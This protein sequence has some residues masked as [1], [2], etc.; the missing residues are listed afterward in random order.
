MPNA[1]PVVIK[2][3]HLISVY[4]D[5]GV[6]NNSTT[7]RKDNYLRRRMYLYRMVNSH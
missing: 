5:L 7:V 1:D 3:Y 6:T 4:T 2:Q